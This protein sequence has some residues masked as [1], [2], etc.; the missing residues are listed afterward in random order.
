MRAGAWYRH[1]GVRAERTRRRRSQGSSMR[2]ACAIAI[3]ADDCCFG[4]TPPLEH[5]VHPVNC[6]SEVNAPV[7]DT[8]GA[9]LFGALSIWG[10]VSL[11][12][13]CRERLLEGLPLQGDERCRQ[14]PG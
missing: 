5:P 14:V 8:V 13:P 2:L 4:M 9:I 6:T 11:V 12:R 10:V 1:M 7:G 3:V